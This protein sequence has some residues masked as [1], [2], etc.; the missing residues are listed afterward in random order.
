MTSSRLV[1]DM[2][3]PTFSRFCGISRSLDPADNYPTLNR[4]KLWEDKKN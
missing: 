3:K 2:F 4:I 1:Q